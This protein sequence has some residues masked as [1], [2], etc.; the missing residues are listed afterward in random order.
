VS[1][2]SAWP[3]ALPDESLQFPLQTIPRITI[4]RPRHQPIPVY[5]FDLFPVDDAPASATLE[6]R[7]WGENGRVGGFGIYRGPGVG[8]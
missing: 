8:T 6:N 5:P 3:A 7:G 1:S 4:D 2:F